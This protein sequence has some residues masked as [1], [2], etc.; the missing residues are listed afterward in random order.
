MQTQGQAAAARL[1]PFVEEVLAPRVCPISHPLTAEVFQTP[2]RITPAEASRGQYK[3]VQLGWH[4]GPVWSTAWFRVRGQV[5][6]EMAGGRVCLRFSTAT[7]ALLW[8]DGIPYHGF[9]VNRD[10]AVLFPKAIGSETVDLLVEAACNHVLGITDQLF[11]E[12]PEQQARWRESTPGRFERCELVTVDQDAWRLMRTFEFARLLLEELPDGSPLLPPLTFALERVTESPSP[13]WSIA[14]L[15]DALSRPGSLPTSWCWTVGHAHLDTAWLWPIAETERKA[16][17]TFANSLRLMERFPDYHFLCTQ[18]QQYQWVKERSPELFEQIRRRVREGR[19]EPLGALWIEPDCNLPSGESFVR[20]ILH[21][22]R[23]WKENFPDLPPQRLAY[24][25]DTFGFAASLPQIFRLAGL[26]TFITNKLWWNQTNEFPFTHFRWRGINGTEILSHL[27]PGQEY[28]ATNTPFELLRGQRIAIRKD[29]Y[30]LPWLQPFGFGDGGGGP[31]DWN[32]LYSE[33][34]ANCPEL[35]GTAFLAGTAGFCRELHQGATR[36]ESRGQPLPTYEGELYLE[37]HRGTFTTQARVKRDNAEAE[38]SLRIAE[39]LA[40]AGPT[41]LS[42]SVRSNAA[43]HLNESW[44]LTLLNQ[45]HDILPGSSIGEV[46]RDAHKDHDSVQRACARLQ[47]QATER[48]AAAADTSSFQR[49]VM[50]LNPSSSDATAA[51]LWKDKQGVVHRLLA[52]GVPAMGFRIFQGVTSDSSVVQR[53]DRTLDNGL[54]RATIDDIGRVSSLSVC[55]GPELAASPLNQLVM[56]ADHPPHWDAWDVEE[57]D[58]ES[59]KP[60]ITPAQI[61]FGDAFG[62]PVIRTSRP[63]GKASRIEQTFRL[64]P[65]SPRLSIATRVHWHEDHTLL[66]VLFPTTVRAPL[67]TCEIPFGH[68]QRPTTRDNP[69]DKAKFEV[70]AHRWMDLSEPGTQGKPGRGLAILNNCKYGHSC[71]GSVMGL[72]LLRAPTW[73]DPQAD[74][75]MHEFTYSIMPHTGDWRAAGVDREAELMVR[76]MW[77]M[78]LEPDRTGVCGQSWA[79]FRIS[80]TASVRIAAIKPAESGDPRTLIMRLHENHGR[81]GSCQ[82]D[83]ALPVSAVQSVDLLER[84]LDIPMTHDAAARSTAFNIKPFQIITFAVRLEG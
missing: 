16:L 14:L 65:S 15:H 59:P 1:K 50:V 51:V 27:T 55:G 66:R 82:V 18:P 70:P 52:R 41:R 24:L 62:L 17:R 37:R 84:P 45:F 22:N 49:P 8:R 34:S 19:W 53:V 32:I 69:I 72:S 38:S 74:R 81:C 3:P 73:P 36:V 33:L 43:H 83:W 64:D 71:H 79:P 68:L 48:W 54:I 47:Q 4:W 5:P 39:W 28:N 76:P 7:E 46:Y 80:G 58:L 40:F 63:I 44:Q 2:D 25:P 6:R 10:T 77:A 31:T 67:A 26:D 29:P 13:E 9:D 61:K 11:W 35:P 30:N 60:V 20:Q 12:P 42:E 57:S 21:A 23:F 75:G 56:Y 78:P